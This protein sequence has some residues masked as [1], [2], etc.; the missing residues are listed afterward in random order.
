MISG[1]MMGSVTVLQDI[2]PLKELEQ[3][4][5]EFIAMVTHELRAPIT[6]VEQQLNVILEQTAGEMN[7]KQE[8]ILSPGERENA[9][10][11]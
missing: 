9:G 6:A 4:K 5:S 3:M 8:E 1:E 2:S 10:V 11:F 7:R